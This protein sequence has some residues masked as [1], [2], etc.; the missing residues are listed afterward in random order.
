MEGKDGYTLIEL[1]VVI[2]IIG[3]FILTIPAYSKYAQQVKL[4]GAAEQVKSYLQE[5]QSLALNPR[6]RER[7]A[8]PDASGPC[9]QIFFNNNITANQGLMNIQ[10]ASTAVSSSSLSKDII[11][12][13]APSPVVF[14]QNDKGA[15]F[16][17]A[18]TR[19]I[20]L[21]STK[22]TKYIQVTIA[23]ETGVIQTG[24]IY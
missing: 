6:G 15:V 2:F 18:G 5:A 1:L 22:L 17:G 4:K 16:N 7:G 20:T 24:N 8:F 11:F 14:C 21:Y 12:S 23:Q 10:T 19:E 3:L 13:P 9:Y